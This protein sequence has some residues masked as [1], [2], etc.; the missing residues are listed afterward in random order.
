EE[1]DVAVEHGR[2]RSGGRV[3]LG[4]RP[5]VGPGALAPR[6][7][8]KP[9]RESRRVIQKR[10]ERDAVVARPLPGREEV[11]RGPVEVEARG[12]R[13]PG[14]RAGAEGLGQAGEVPDR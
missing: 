12:D 13:G 2:P 5:A 11:A 10:R 1:I 4:E 9:G 7:D 3:E 6:V 8:R 14:E